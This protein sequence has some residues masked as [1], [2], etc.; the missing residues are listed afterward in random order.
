[1]RA[2]LDKWRGLALPDKTLFQLMLVG[3]LLDEEKCNFYK[4]LAIACGFL[5]KVRVIKKKGKENSRNSL[6]PLS[7]FACFIFIIASL[8]RI[9]LEKSVVNRSDIPSVVDPVIDEW[10][11]SYR[12]HRVETSFSP[13]FIYAANHQSSTVLSRPVL[14]FYILFNI[15]F[16][17]RK[18]SI[19]EN[20]TVA[21]LLLLFVSR[22]GKGKTF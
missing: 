20:G 18:N 5:G 7:P 16:Y 13:F 14:L 1:M 4:F 3:K 21:V 8:D 6:V 17:Q 2:M 11:F 12:W 10:V 9:L 19:V 22:E 15:R